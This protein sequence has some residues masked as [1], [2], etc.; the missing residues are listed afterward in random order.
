MDE[1]TR[2][3][4]LTEA[5]ME[6]RTQFRNGREVDQFGQMIIGI[7]EQAN[8]PH[9]LELVQ[10]AYNQ[11]NQSFGLSSVEILTEAMNYMHDK[12]DQLQKNA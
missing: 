7:V 2:L 6:Y 8:D 9:L 5:I 1:L 4:L 3:Q 10:E 11:R 12:I